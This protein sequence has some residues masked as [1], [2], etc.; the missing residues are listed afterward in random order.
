MSKEAKV[1]WWSLDG[2]VGAIPYM[3][4][5]LERGLLSTIFTAATGTH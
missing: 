4:M 2:E 1:R 5:L 3:P